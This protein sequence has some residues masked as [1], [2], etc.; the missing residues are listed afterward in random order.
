[1]NDIDEAGAA[2][3]TGS[4]IR[5]SAWRT[6]G[7]SIVSGAST[8]LGGGSGTGGTGGSGMGTGACCAAGASSGAG[9]G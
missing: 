7:I 8:A 2:S 4:G 1:M 9:I 6:F 5:M 3:T